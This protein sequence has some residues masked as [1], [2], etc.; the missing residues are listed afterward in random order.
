M[1]SPA[2]PRPDP[3]GSSGATA[4][5]SRRRP[6]ASGPRRRPVPPAGRAGHGPASAGLPAPVSPAHTVF[7]TENLTNFL[8]FP[9]APDALVVFGAG[10]EAPELLAGLSARR[11]VYTGDLDT[12]GLAILDR[13]RAHLPHT[14]SILMDLA[15]LQA[16]REMWVS[17]KTQ[18]TR[19]LPQLLPMSRPSTTRCGRTC[20]ATMC[21]WSR[22]GSGSARCDEVGGSRGQPRNRARL[23]VTRGRAAPGDPCHAWTR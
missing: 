2:A 14:Q 11:V 1:W 8:A 10:N 16:H 18:I 9:P 21:G 6:C 20:T 22:S 7:V 19:E 17:E 4:S 13:F 15:T 3:V 23:V 5:S 12:H